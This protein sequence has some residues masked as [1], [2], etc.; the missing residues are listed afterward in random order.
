MQGA[1]DAIDF[2]AIAIKRA[3]HPFIA[4]MHKAI[5]GMCL[6]GASNRKAVSVFAPNL[7]FVQVSR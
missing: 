5:N 6:F 1:F 3:L 7:T 4:V 2:V